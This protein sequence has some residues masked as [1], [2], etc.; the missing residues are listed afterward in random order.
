MRGEH[1][2]LALSEPR[3]A[4]VTWDR[5]RNQTALGK[6]LLAVSTCGEDQGQSSE[7][8]IIAKQEPA[9]L[10]QI[11][12]E[13][14][15]LHWARSCTA[16]GKRSG[17]KSICEPRKKQSMDDRHGLADALHATAALSR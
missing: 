4:C 15:Q 11:R 14:V 3:G 2:P 8:E 9:A 1:G 16:A 13:L 10:V 12:P 17:S 6:L 7:R 5:N